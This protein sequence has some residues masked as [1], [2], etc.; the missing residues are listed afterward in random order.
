[1]STTVKI[2]KL[3]KVLLN[4]ESLV[5]I[6]IVTPHQR[7]FGKVA[8]QAQEADRVCMLQ[9]FFLNE[10]ERQHDFLIVAPFK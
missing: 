6:S 1:L 9:K 5:E 2:I 10:F 8:E 7:D 3:L 4:V